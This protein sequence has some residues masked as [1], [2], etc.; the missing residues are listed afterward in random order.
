[1][2][3]P[4]QPDRAEGSSGPAA[5]TDGAWDLLGTAF[6]VTTT[7]AALGHAVHELLAAFPAA[8]GPA[9]ADRQF[10]LVDGCALHRH[11]VCAHT[12][13]SV[14]GFDDAGELLSWLLTRLNQAALDAFEG[15]AVHAAVLARGGSAIAFPAESGTGKTTL[16]AAGLRAG[17]DYVSDEALCVAPRSGR[18]V[19]YPR[20]LA[21][22]AWS[23]RAVGLEGIAAID[24]AGGE[25]ALPP[26]RLGAQVA[27][28]PLA[29]DHVAHLVRRA[30]P[31]TLRP[32]HRTDAL[33]W[34]LRRSFNHYKRP[35]ESFHVA[36]GMA[37]GARAWRLEC[38]DPGEAAQLLLDR[39]S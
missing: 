26:A 14:R 19:P 7:S 12:K 16:A 17:F 8:A 9:T 3:P 23:R 35:L 33:A 5:A 31:S 30:G 21:L 22:S 36:A 6:R 18:L 2:S 37:R 24:L 38:G 27:V 10:L 4:A 28:A 15:L 34:L 20:A 32:V 29:L 25:V 11:E 13:V 39:L 1:M